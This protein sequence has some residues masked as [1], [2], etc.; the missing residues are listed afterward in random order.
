MS[1]EYFAASAD[2]EIGS[3]LWER[4]DAHF[5]WLRSSGR[6]NKIAKSYA[7]SVGETYNDTDSRASEVVAGGEQGETLL[8]VENHYRALGDSVTNLLT[9]ERPTIECGA[10]NSDSESIG[11]ALL[12]N[13]L[14]DYHL[15]KRGLEA[16][17]KRSC[18]RGTFQSEGFIYVPWD[19]HAGEPFMPLEDEE[20]NVTGQKKTGDV[21]FYA[22]GPLDV[23]RDIF[24]DCWEQLQWVM[25]RTWVGK[26]EMLARY[27]EKA[28]SIMG[29]DAKGDSVRVES[30]RKGVE[31]DLIECWDFFHKSC[32]SVPGGRM[33]TLLASDVVL[34]SGPNPY[35]DGLPVYNYFPD[36]LDG[37]PFGDTRMWDLMGPQDAVNGIDSQ[38]ITATLNAG[39]NNWLVPNK[40]NISVSQLADSSNAITYDGELAPTR[41]PPPEVSQSLFESKALKIQAMETL[42]G[43]SSVTRG[44]P[45][46]AVGQDASGAKLALLDAKSIQNN[47]GAEKAF[48]RLVRDVCTAILRR[49]RDFGGDIERLVKLAGK[50]NQYLVKQF[51]G[52]D[53]KDV[54]VIKVELSN[55]V[56]RTTAGKMAVADKA[57]ELGVIKPGQ[58]DKYLMLMRTGQE[59]PLFE[60]EQAVQMR[61]RGENERL[62]EGQGQHGALISDP[63]WKEIPEHLALLDNPSLRDPTPQNEA[64]QARILEAVQQH[65]NWFVQMPPWMVMMRGGPEAL[66]IYQQVQMS[67]AP[68][69]LPPPGPDASMTAPPAPGAQSG[70]APPASG[71]ETATDPMGS[72]PEMPGQPRMAS[73]PGG[74]PA[75]NL[76]GNALQ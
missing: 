55:P 4:R 24:A 18:R 76:G 29:L 53:L 20:G 57:V 62:L 11:R 7:L 65:I 27:P 45:S 38:I 14:I 71:A 73:Q 15:T 52:S 56:L 50:S 1:D 22:L 12:A 59:G 31:S 49:Y 66:A 19:P 33:V 2:D 75:V 13:G 30:R 67:M 8:A 70:T 48:I 26:F 16:L 36:E 61:I 3:R 6:L 72:R 25:V 43:V 63:H 58:L 9:S 40:A 74:E 23:V 28:A 60:V 68:P 47:S 44:Q 37:T 69:M 34:Y 46:A 42:S 64:I 21:G 39:V 41:A 17:L 32:S 5:E 10:A 54:E 35:S 51:V